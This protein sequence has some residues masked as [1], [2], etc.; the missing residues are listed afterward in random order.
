[1]A[2]T[3]GLDNVRR[4]FADQFQVE[5]GRLVYRKSLKGPPIPVSEAERDGYIAQ[6]RRGLGRVYWSFVG[7]IIVAATAGF[8]VSLAMR[9]DPYILT[10]ITVL[11]ALA[12]FVLLWRRLW[13]APAREMAARLP[14]GHALDRGETQRRML[15]RMTWGQFVLGLVAPAIVLARVGSDYDLLYGWNRLWLVGS[16][17]YL[18]LLAWQAYRKW[19]L[20][21]D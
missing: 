10:E 15:H 8:I 17:L 3:S 14:V 9:L 6:F 7:G 19:R 1:M 13:N 18:G 5:D 4:M 20:T 16:A 12:V 2:G 21:R 11:A